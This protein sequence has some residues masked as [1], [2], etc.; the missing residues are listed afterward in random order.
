MTERYPR[1]V[2]LNISE[3]A[4]ESTAV[5]KSPGVEQRRGAG[6]MKRP[7]LQLLAGQLKLFTFLLATNCFE[8]TPTAL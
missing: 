2:G 7:S 3:A 1:G 8:I 6:R 4:L 5:E